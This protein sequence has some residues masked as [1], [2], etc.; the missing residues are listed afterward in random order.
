DERTRTFPVRVAVQNVIEKGGPV[1]KGGMLAQVTLQTGETQDATLIPKD[2]LVLG[3][4]VPMVYLVVPDPAGPTKLKVAPMPV[5]I[6]VAADGRIQVLPSA[7]ARGAFVKPGDQVVVLGN[8]RL[9]PDQPITISKVAESQP[10]AS[11]DGVGS[12]SR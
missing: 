8:E 5:E 11:N 4:P 2:A 6:G 7:A 3:G 10:S 1:I 12:K 9:R